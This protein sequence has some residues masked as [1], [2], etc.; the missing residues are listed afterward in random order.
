MMI[1][2]MD[3]PG[4]HR[5]AD[6]RLAGPAHQ[7]AVPRQR[8]RAARLPDRRARHGLLLRRHGAQLRAPVDR[9]GRHGA[10]LLPRARRR[11]CASSASTASRC[12]SSR[13]CASGWRAWR[14]TSKRRACS[15][16][17]RRGRSSRAAC[18]R[19]NRRW[20]RSSSASSPSASPTPARE[21]L[22][23]NGQLHP[24]EP[25]RAA[26]R[27]PA[28]ALS[29]RAAAR[30][31][32]RH[33]RGAAQHHRHARLRPAAQVSGAS[34]HASC[35]PTPEQ[36]ELKDAVARFCTEQIT[37][38][39]LTAWEREPRGI[40]DAH[41]GDAIADARLVRARRCPRRAA[42]AG[43]AWSRW[44]C[45]L[46]ECARGLIPRSVINA[47]RGGWALARLDPHA[48]EL[49]G[50][51][52]RRSVVALALDEQTA[53]MPRALRDRASPARRRR[54]VQRREVVRRQRR[55]APT[56]SSS[57]AREA[58]RRL[59]GAGGRR[60]HRAPRRCAPSTA[61]SRPS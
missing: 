52:A 40:D 35:T 54:A 46:Q 21:I 9:L 29:H 36:Q 19:R 32:R 58:Q 49:A 15:A 56:A 44:R 22:G 45:L 28:V 2:P 41:A 53:A 47:I 38:E 60:A 57:P 31:R 23:L 61:R 43:S 59:A 48:P 55:S 39:R 5:A 12:A 18:R 25:T 6:L 37:P 42:A 10:A 30:L 20:R 3:A 17:R 16:W 51:R 14:S 4:V 24:D 50:R 11:W 7:R 1:V 26:A 27:A 33:Q 8:A 34:R 13:G